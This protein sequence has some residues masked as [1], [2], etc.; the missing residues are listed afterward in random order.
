MRKDRRIKVVKSER[1]NMS[2]ISQSTGIVDRNEMH[3]V[4]GTICIEHSIFCGNNNFPLLRTLNNLVTQ[5]SV[6]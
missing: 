2:M 4:F 5:I 6:E 1:Y 3:G